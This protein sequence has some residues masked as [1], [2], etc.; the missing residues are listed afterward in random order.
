MSYSSENMC[1]SAL[2]SLKH[3]T[4]ISDYEFVCIV[5]LCKQKYSYWINALKCRGLW[6]VYVDI[7][8]RNEGYI[9]QNPLSK[10]FPVYIKVYKLRKKKD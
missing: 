10:S 9:K 1:E 5:R 8:L 2:Q 7:V 4:N 6:E 3:C